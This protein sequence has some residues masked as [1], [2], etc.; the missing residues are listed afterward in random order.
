MFTLS[1]KEKVLFSFV[2]IAA[3]TRLVPHPPNFAPITAMSLFAGAYF[4]RKQLS[5][6]VPLLAMLISDL[7]LGF[8]TIS[9]F[10]YISFA[11][12]TWMGQQQNKVTPKLVLLGSV[13][14][15]VISNLGVWLLY[16]PKTIE[17]LLTCFTLAIPFF[18]TSLL[19]DVFYSVVL[20]FGFS[21]VSRRW[22]LS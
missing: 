19:G 10:V 18:A 21:A 20:V 16:Y 2:L 11:L 6:I 8:Y 17:G 22:Q 13:L 3:L 5:F 7:F 1:K 15:F 12:I 14:F 9:I 4:T